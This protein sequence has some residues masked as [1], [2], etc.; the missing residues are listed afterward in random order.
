MDTLQILETG[1]WFLAGSSLVLLL[2]MA[3]TGGS[4]AA[5]SAG[6]E[7]LAPS[8]PLPPGGGDAMRQ[9]VQRQ[10]RKQQKQEETRGRMVQAGLYHRN[11]T[12]MFALVRVLLGASMMVMGIAVA[13]LGLLPMHLSLLVAALCGMAGTIAPSFYIDH[14][15]KNRQNQIRRALPDALDVLSICLEGGLSLAGS[16]V[17]V[18]RELEAAHP[19]LATELAIVERS[20]QLG[21]TTGQSL[22]Q[23]ANRFELE[24]LRSLSSVVSQ[25][26]TLGTSVARALEVYAETLRTK[27]SLHAEEKAQKAVIKIL[28]PTLFCIFPG[29]FV[30]IL[31][32]AAI[33]VYRTLVLKM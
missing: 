31:G 8:A 5:E 21:L 32:P 19:M 26:E 20:S 27:R 18:S 6:S 1:V 4:S 10:L 9:Q 12:I 17:R 15:R 14:I 7:G 2:F 11:A 33:Q 3:L 13:R 30:V 16:L 23:M 24:E 28:F 29:L 25:A 22:R